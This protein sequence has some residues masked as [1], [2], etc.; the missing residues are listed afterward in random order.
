MSVSG[1]LFLTCLLFSAIHASPLMKDAVVVDDDFKVEVSTD[2]TYSISIKKQT[3]LPNAHTFFRADGFPFSTADDTLVLKGASRSNGSDKLGGWTSMDF[4][5]HAGQYIIIARVKEYTQSNLGDFVIFEQHYKEGALMTGTFNHNEVI[6]SF[7]S[8]YITDNV[9]DLGFLSYGG[10]MVGDTD[11]KMGRW[12]KG[13]AMPNSGID[14]GPLC[15][16]NENRDAVVI[17]PFNQF[18]AGS[19]WH[20]RLT[21][22]SVNWGIMGRIGRVPADFVYQ[23]VVFYSAQGINK[24]FEGWGKLL[25]TYHAKDQ[26]MREADFTLNYLGY[27]TDGGAFY[28]YNTEKNKNYEQTILDVRAE[29]EK[30]KIPYRYVQYDSYWYYKG[31]GKGVKT[32]EPMPDIFPNGLQFLYNMTGWPAGA[33]NRFWASDTTYAKQNGGQFDFIVEILKAVPMSEDFWD[34]L[35]SNARKWGLI[36]YE[37]D[38]LNDEFNGMNALLTNISV[39]RD[40]LMLMGRSARK[41]GITIMY[42][43]SYSREALQSLEIPAVTMA[44]SSNDYSPG[45]DNW[46]IGIS[47]IFAD[48][49]GLAPFKDTFWSTTNQPG[50]SYNKSEPNPGLHLTVATLSTAAVGPGDSV[51]GMNV[52]LIET[53]CDADGRILKP[54]KPAMAIDAQIIQSALGGTVGPVGEVWTTYSNIQNF[55]FGIILAAAISNT[56]SL[57]PSDTTFADKLQDGK[58]YTSQSWMSLTDFTESKPIT[59]QGCS[60]QHYCLYYIAPVLM[61]SPEV[62]LLGEVPAKVVPVS[63]QRFSQI[64]I[65]TDVTLTLTGGVKEKVTVWYSVSGT[66]K[67]HTCQLGTT[68][69]ATLTLLGGI[70]RSN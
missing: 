1:H 45:N 55:Y 4:E 37:Q 25:R 7:P 58:V 15:I 40:W 54:T 51:T 48:A 66:S 26:K 43:M 17:S 42:C 63:P 23:T 21:T 62:V 41:N 10:I 34:Y 67:S 33:H 46:K 56:F 59:I 16:F 30:N 53:C 61:S 31:I 12:Q 50:N 65:D 27:W 6:S 70:C 44:R 38:W 68:G 9:P 35:F 3:W 24:A 29:V 64:S 20:D 13:Q 47:S 19:V 52:S 36:L 2:G 22:D 60:T 69:E 39:G 49:I 57:R 8:F 5:Y 32:W 14:G 18:M 28:Y 11:K